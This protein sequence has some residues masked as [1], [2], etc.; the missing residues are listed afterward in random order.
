[1]KTAMSKRALAAVFLVLLALPT[2]TAE[3]KPPLPIIPGA[4]G[5]G[6]QTPAGS[7]RHLQDVSLEPGWDASLV[8]HWNFNDGTAGGGTLTGDAAIVKRDKEHALSLKGKG[9]LKLANARGY[10][11]PG[12]QCIVLDTSAKDGSIEIPLTVPPGRYLVWARAK[13]R[14]RY[15][16][17]R[18]EVKCAGRGE[19]CLVTGVGEKLFSD[20]TWSWRRVQSLSGSTVPRRRPMWITVAGDHPT[21]SIQY[22]S[23]YIELDQIYL[24]TS[25]HDL[26]A[27]EAI[28]FKPVD[29]YRFQRR[30]EPTRARL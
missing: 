15:Q 10:V 1:M 12:G 7:G 22:L 27:A 25:V 20:Y 13:S 2:C 6:M 24:S 14:G 8:G 11:K 17:A 29:E 30:P 28:H 16:I 9:S 18:V 19:K 5:F 4:A 23:G 26:P 21:L 3:D